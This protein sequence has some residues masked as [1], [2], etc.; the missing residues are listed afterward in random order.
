[1]KVTLM[2]V[3]VIKDTIR[4][5]LTYPLD[6]KLSYRLNKITK[7]LQSMLE[8]IEKKRLALVDEMGVVNEKD[9]T[10]NVPEDKREEFYNK[11]TEYL[12][13]EVEADIQLIPYELLVPMKL[14]ADDVGK[15]EKFIAEPEEL[16]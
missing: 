8:D 4:K 9:Q 16:K 11:L 6:F 7:K 5:V 12:K 15:L 1:M 3:S 13:T 10:R 14:S 2:E